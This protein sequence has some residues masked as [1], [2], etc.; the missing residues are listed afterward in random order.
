M[1]AKL[2]G[3]II[4]LILVIATLVT[5]LPLTV[6]AETIEIEKSKG[7]YVKSIKLAQAKTEDEAKAILEGDGYIDLVNVKC[8]PEV[9]YSFHSESGM[10]PAYHMNKRHWITAALDGS[11]DD[12]KI[13]WLLD[14]S[15][16]L[17]GIKRKK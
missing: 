14:I 7:L 15:Y 5:T 10:F 3:K 13:K 11:A 2:Y 1:K 8:D 4:S 12:D 17:T 9:I 16:D 6:F